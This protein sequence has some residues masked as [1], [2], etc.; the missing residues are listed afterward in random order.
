MSRK[1]TRKNGWTIA[2]GVDHATGA[3]V[4]V[5]K[6]GDPAES[7][8]LEIDSLGICG[9]PSMDKRFNPFVEEMLARFELF[10]Q[11]HPGYLPTLGH[12]D[13]MD[14]FKKIDLE[15]AEEMSGHVRDALHC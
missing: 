6:D 8:Q 2:F 4:Q 1:E 5:W 3:F 10:K 9:T 15:W 11:Y 7:P 14:L 13:I 12:Q